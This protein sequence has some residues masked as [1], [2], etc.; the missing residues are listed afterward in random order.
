MTADFKL[1]SWIKLPDL[2]SRLR[3]FLKSELVARMVPES[4]V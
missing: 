3:R 4:T 1:L 2:I